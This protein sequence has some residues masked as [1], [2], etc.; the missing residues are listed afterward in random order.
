M[1][2][3]IKTSILM[4]LALAMGA[5]SFL[6]EEHNATGNASAPLYAFFETASTDNIGC[7]PTATT[8]EDS[9][10][11]SSALRAAYSLYITSQYA[12]TV[13]VTI[14]SDVQTTSL[15]NKTIRFMASNATPNPGDLVGTSAYTIPNGTA[16]PLYILGTGNACPQDITAKLVGVLNFENFTQF[17]NII[18]IAESCG[19]VAGTGLSPYAAS[20]AVYGSSY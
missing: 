19:M 20:Q 17:Q 7:Y 11:V 12:V 10:I 2:T 14:P 6:K 3:F 5:C 4:G 9:T 18:A 16:V 15:L 1:K 8:T 13:C